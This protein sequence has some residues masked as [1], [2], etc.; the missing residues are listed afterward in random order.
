[1]IALIKQEVR[2]LS[3]AV[4]LGLGLAFFH[5]ENTP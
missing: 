3:P 2:K 5:F 4:R 1:M